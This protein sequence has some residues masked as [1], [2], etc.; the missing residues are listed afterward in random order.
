MQKSMDSPPETKFPASA[1]NSEW[2]K[3]LGTLALLVLLAWLIWKLYL[4][5]AM[6]GIEARELA[7]VTAIRQ[8][9]DHS[10]DTLAAYPQN[11]YLYGALQAWLLSWLPE[12]NDILLNR[13]FSLACLLAS[14]VPLL[15]AAGRLTAMTGESPHRWAWVLPLGCYL[16]PFMIEIPFS[17]GT[18]NYLG[19]LLANSVLWIS[20]CRFRGK[21]VLAGLLLVGCFLTKQ[22]FLLASLYVV[23][24]NLLLC[25][26]LRKAA[27]HIA[28]AGAIALGGCVLCFTS[29]QVFYSFVHHIVDADCAKKRAMQKFCAYSLYVLPMVLPAAWVSAKILLRHRRG[30]AGRFLASLRENMRSRVY[31]CVL[32]N[33]GLTTLVLVKVGGHSGALGQLYFTQLLTPPLLLLCVLM[34]R[35]GNA[36]LQTDG[37]ALLLL[38]G[39]AWHAPGAFPEEYAALQTQSQALAAYAEDLAKGLSVRGSCMTA[40]YDAAHTL[41]ITENGQ[42][43]YMDTVWQEGKGVE[44]AHARIKPYLQKNKVSREELLEGLRLGRWQVVYTDGCTY[45]PEAARKEL[46]TGYRRTKSLPFA[47]PGF[48]TELVR[49]ESLDRPI[50]A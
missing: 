18:P 27:Q 47:F 34:Q 39:I 46:E 42:Q 25:S 26:S 41:P 17:L 23:L 45:M 33:V 16:L 6:P 12:W 11:I 40:F 32:A 3:V 29:D 49:W 7:N 1:G 2:S 24:Y 35:R 43:Q 8:L 19:L 21:D 28:V 10:F 20:L 48:K 22:Y 30:F 5:C 13:I 38:A 15:A 14:A 9:R 4:I 37:T 50:K 31:L 36:I 44:W